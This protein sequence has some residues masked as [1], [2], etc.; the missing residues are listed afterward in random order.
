MEL[1]PF[2]VVV[3]GWERYAINVNGDVL[4]REVNTVLRGYTDSYRNRA[5]SLTD[6][7]GE[8][9]ILQ[10]ARLV[11]STF[12]V[13]TTLEDRKVRFA[14]G[15]PENC[16]ISNLRTSMAVGRLREDLVP[17]TARH[18]IATSIR[19]APG[20]IDEYIYPNATAF[21][22]SHSCDLSSVYKVL[23]GEGRS[24]LGY[25]FHYEWLP[26]ES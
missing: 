19:S 10:V 8:R 18:L 12:T 9:T 17:A 11:L 21:A 5:V 3:P 2:F 4:N 15:N 14:D 13:G 22:K 1:V 20:T 24:L 25:S 23:R 26:V 7:T 16:H 6:S